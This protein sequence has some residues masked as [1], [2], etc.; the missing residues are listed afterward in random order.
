MDDL[1]KSYDPA[2]SPHYGM[3]RERQALPCN[4]GG[5]A[6]RVNST[7]EEIDEY[8][9]GRDVPGDE[10]CAA[11]F[12]CRVCGG[13]IVGK[14]NSPE[15]DCGLWTSIEGRLGDDDSD[16]HH[17]CVG[18]SVEFRARIFRDQSA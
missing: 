13:R 1:E 18:T 14:C 17:H 7:D 8:G 16:T 5:Y 6:D 11:A 4:C 12:V 10:C 2:K 9:C 15:M 3:P